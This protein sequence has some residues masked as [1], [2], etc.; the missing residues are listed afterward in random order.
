MFPLLSSIPASSSLFSTSFYFFLLLSAADKLHTKYQPSSL[1]CDHL[2]VLA[3]FHVIFI[4]EFIV[5]G[6][7]NGLVS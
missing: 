2:V 7:I 5:G 4:D 1:F 6:T 3:R